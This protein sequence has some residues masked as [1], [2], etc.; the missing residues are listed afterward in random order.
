MIKALNAEMISLI[1]K[2]YT[3][4]QYT[5]VRMDAK[6]YIFVNKSP[7]ENTYKILKK[8]NTNFTTAS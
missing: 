6:T 1:K 8:T 2:I 5:V 4:Q 7:N 3:T